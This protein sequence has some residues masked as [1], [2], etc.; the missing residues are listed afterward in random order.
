MQNEPQRLQRKHQK[1]LCEFYFD[2]SLFNLV[3]ANTPKVENFY[4]RLSNY[5]DLKDFPA[6]IHPYNNLLSEWKH[7]KTTEALL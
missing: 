3:S 4:T 7:S 2:D 5:V 6:A 1:Q